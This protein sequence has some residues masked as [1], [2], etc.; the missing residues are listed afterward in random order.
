MEEK[1]NLELNEEEL[2]QVTA[3]LPPVSKQVPNFFK[4]FFF[5]FTKKDEPSEKHASLHIE[6]QT[7]VDK[8][9]L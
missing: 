9:K 3:G 1:K 4:S 2:E 8:M 7:P 6:K 5:K